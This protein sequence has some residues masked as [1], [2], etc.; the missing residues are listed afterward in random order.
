MQ[1]STKSSNLSM[2]QS[3]EIFKNVGHGISLK[4]L[5]INKV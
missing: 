4:S 2:K 5:I 1:L 3:Q